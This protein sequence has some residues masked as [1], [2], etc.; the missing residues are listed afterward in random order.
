M[1]KMNAVGICTYARA[2]AV[3]QVVMVLDVHSHLGMVYVKR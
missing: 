3:K 1:V 2:Y